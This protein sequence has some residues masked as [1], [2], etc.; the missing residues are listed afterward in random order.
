MRP[1][2]RQLAASSSPPPPKKKANCR[3][4]KATLAKK[5]AIVMI[6]TSRFFTWASSW[7]ISPRARRGRA[8][9][10]AGGGAT[11]AFLGDRPIAK[12]FGTS[13]SATATFGLGRSAWM[14]RRSI[15]A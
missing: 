15:I 10:D 7:A 4:I 3:I 1:R 8:C 11:V 2:R 5:L 9:H 14:Q 12:A 6:I 13:V